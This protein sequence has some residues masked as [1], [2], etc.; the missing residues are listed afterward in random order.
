MSP[1]RPAAS[2]SHLTKA[3]ALERAGDLNGALAAYEAALAAAPGDPDILS[4]LA[5]LAGRMGLWEVGAQLWAQVSLADPARLEAVD[6]QARAL[7]ELGRF[8]PAISLLRDA[9]MAH[10]QEARLWN[11]L[12]VT[13][14][15]DSQAQLAL[16]FLDEAIRLDPRNAAAVYNRGNALF[17]LD[18]TE[19]AAVSF[20][21]ARS[22]SRKP[23]DTAMI[24]FAAAT[25]ALARGDLATGWTAYESR[26]SP[27]LPKALSFDVPHQRW[28][29]GAPLTGR[30]MLVVGEQGLGDELM[31]ANV[32]PDLLAALGPGGRLSLAIEP[33][34][35]ALFGRSLP[36]VNVRAYATDHAGP[37]PRRSA[38]DLDDGPL[39]DL[40]APMG[41]LPSAFRPTL[42]A[43][44][45]TAGYLRPDP[46]EVARW[47]A[48]LGDGPP[49]VGLSWRSGK[50]AGDR[51]R[52]YPPAE[53]WTPL[54]RT[55]GVRFVNVQYGD[56]AEELA[57]FRAASG[58]EIL[59]P[60][61]LDLREDIDR[62]AALLC[63]LDLTV[64]VANATGALAGAVGANVAI[65]GAPAAWPRLGTDAL[66]WYP[67]VRAL[68]APAFGEW[69]PPMDAAA[70]LVA[71]LAR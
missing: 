44:P 36:G 55:T 68:S 60:G 58:A 32:L 47:R 25:L 29:P 42:A 15:Q 52:Q 31:F 48:W 67:Q 57:A 46:A 38:P 19:A 28:A 22:L 45:S 49:S 50:A 64:C 7:R 33:R 70:G 39:V 17:D 61:G 20:S 62:L 11:S 66:P 54:L 51:R 34:L 43:F 59:E 16:T 24:D 3:A 56:A 10:P 65:L 27:A 37:Q 6:G 26:F 69:A 21:Q 5:S 12:G 71:A 23:A 35:T 40:W 30:H 53:L 13:L 41:S 8:E 2:A 18:H 14:T 63:A 9:L 4:S 1:L